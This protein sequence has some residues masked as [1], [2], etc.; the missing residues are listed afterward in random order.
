MVAVPD[1]EIG[2]MLSAR[3]LALCPTLYPAKA[4]VTALP[5]AVFR[6]Q[7]AVFG[8]RQGAQAA[9]L[10]ATGPARCVMLR[11]GPD[12]ADRCHPQPFEGRVMILGGQYR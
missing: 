9:A 8:G 1:P 10:E 12:P 3:V 6:R 7:I 5:R 4:P 11:A 2:P